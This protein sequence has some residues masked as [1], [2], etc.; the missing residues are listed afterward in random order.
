MTGEPRGTCS[1]GNEIEWWLCPNE[2]PCPHGAV[3]HDVE[4]LEDSRP[5]CCVEG[6][7]CGHPDP[8]ASRRLDL[9]L[10]TQRVE[11]AIARMIPAGRVLGRV[12]DR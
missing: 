10:A 6:C 5:A 9:A 2:P 4:G 7:Y 8:E 1:C 3:V 11:Q 12:D